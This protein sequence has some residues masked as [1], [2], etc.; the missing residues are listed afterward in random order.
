MIHVKRHYIVFIFLDNELRWRKYL[1][2]RWHIFP[3]NKK[4]FVKRFFHRNGTNV[5]FREYT[6]FFPDN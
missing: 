1:K 6:N 2:F 4:E 5:N 3:S